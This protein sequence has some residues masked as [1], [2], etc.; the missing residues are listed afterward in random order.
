M[1]PRLR[2]LLDDFRR[3]ADSASSD[4]TETG[5]EH[6]S[7]CTGC[8]SAE[9]RFDPVVG[10]EEEGCAGGGAYDCGTD[11]CVD[12]FEA[13]GCQESAAGLETRF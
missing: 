1:L 10:Y 13:A 2:P 8:V 5:C 3:H 9:A 4:F 7:A 6:V 11:A 12:A